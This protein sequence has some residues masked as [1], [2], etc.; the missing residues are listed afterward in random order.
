MFVLNPEQV[1]NKVFFYQEHAD[2]ELLVPYVL[3]RNNFGWHRVLADDLEADDYG[4]K[5]IVMQSKKS[6]KDFYWYLKDVIYVQMHG[7][8]PEG[9]AV[10]QLEVD[11]YSPNNFVLRKLPQ[12]FNNVTVVDEAA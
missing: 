4:N 2:D 1:R 7:A 12:R 9:F 8:V 5:L 11:K 10:R 6:D 3:I